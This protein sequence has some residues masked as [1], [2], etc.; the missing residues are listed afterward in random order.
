M[1]AWDETGVS[2]HAGIS[3]RRPYIKS[4]PGMKPELVSMLALARGD[5]TSSARLG[6]VDGLLIGAGLNGR[7]A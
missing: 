3:E 4:S 1:P 6:L 2:V 7:S 5:L